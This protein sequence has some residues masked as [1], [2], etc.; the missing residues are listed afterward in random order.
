MMKKYI[1][2]L[3]AFFTLCSCQNKTE[4]NPGKAQTVSIQDFVGKTLELKDL[5][6]NVQTVRL[7]T[8]T[9][10]YIG[11]IKDICRVDSFL[12]ILDGATLS[13]SKFNQDGLLLRQISTQGNGPM[14]YIQPMALS[15]DKSHVYLLDLPGMSIISYNQD[16]KAEEEITLSFPCSEFIRTEKGFLCYNMAPTDSLKS[17]V[18][19]SREGKII[20]S[21]SINIFHSQ[22]SLGAKIFCQDDQGNIF[23]NPPITQ[24]IYRWNPD[25]E[26]AE[27]YITFD[28]GSKNFPHDSELNVTRLGELPYAFPMYFFHIQESCLYSFLYQ[29]QS[30]YYQKTSTADKAGSISKQSSYPFFP[31]WQI[32]NKLIGTCPSEFLHLG[33]E[34]EAGEVLLFFSF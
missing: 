5:G 20:D 25:S 2:F 19:I 29:D 8:D 32:G 3:A 34:Q 31:R 16:L 27:E 30:Y 28:F 9:A 26:T 1:L 18:H 17:L 33:S 7:H 21:Y 12:Y 23:I 4:E 11:D 6:C 13:V 14:E 24:T 10:G 22:M 15:A